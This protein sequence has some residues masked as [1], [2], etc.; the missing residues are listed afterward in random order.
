MLYCYRNSFASSNDMSMPAS[1][2][3]TSVPRSIR[4]FTIPAWSC[5]RYQTAGFPLDIAWKHCAEPVCMVRVPA[6]TFGS[7][8]VFF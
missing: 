8:R 7:F 6:R 2:G 4:L 1:F 5:G 3:A